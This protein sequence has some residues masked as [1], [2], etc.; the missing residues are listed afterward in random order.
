MKMIPPLEERLLMKQTLLLFSL[1][2]GSNAVAAE[3]P[4][5]VVYRASDLKA[6]RQKLAPKINEMKV[7]V[8]NLDKFGNHSSMVAH[9]EGPGQVEI[10]ERMSDLFVV[11][12][13]EAVLVVGGEAENTKEVEPGELRGASIKGGE[14]VKLGAG[15]IVHIPPKVPHQVLVDSGKEFTYFVLK[16]EA[17]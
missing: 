15:D 9:R 3:M 11:Q 10:H 12:D 14:R 4:G 13:G 17:K 16:V 1:L 6:Y 8:V 7:A 2:V 5:F